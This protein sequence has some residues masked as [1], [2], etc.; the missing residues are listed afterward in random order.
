MEFLYKLESL[1]TAAVMTFVGIG[2]GAGVVISFAL[3]PLFFILKTFLN[4]KRF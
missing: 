3:L 1:T 2:L 4:K